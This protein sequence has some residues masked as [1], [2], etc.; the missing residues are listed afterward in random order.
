M[1]A[2]LIISTEYRMNQPSV[3]IFTE[4]KYYG[5]LIYPRGR[6]Y[7]QDI[8]YWNNAICSDSGRYFSVN[9]VDYSK[10]EFERICE[11][12]N[13][14]TSNEAQLKSYPGWEK[15][16]EYTSKKSKEYKEYLSWS[17]KKQLEINE[18]LKHNNPIDRIIYAAQKELRQILL[19]KSNEN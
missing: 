7:P 9:E 16:P 13:V 5:C 3:F 15:G 11:L 18:I 10:D 4:G 14:I 19:S 12:Q 17:E 1:N 6:N 8:N 2:H